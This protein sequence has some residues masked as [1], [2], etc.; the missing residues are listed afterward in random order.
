M[1]KIDKLL[2]RLW[3]IFDLKYVFIS[4]NL[5]NDL[6]ALATVTGI[7]KN[8]TKSLQNW[9]NEVIS[10]LSHNNF[11]TS[12]TEPFSGISILNSVMNDRASEIKSSVKSWSYKST[13]FDM[14]FSMSFTIIFFKLQGYKNV[15]NDVSEEVLDR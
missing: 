5:E 13:I 8:R 12:P 2:S 9:G 11:K 4:F 15:N 6:S 7:V 3:L 14:D 10:L 1:D